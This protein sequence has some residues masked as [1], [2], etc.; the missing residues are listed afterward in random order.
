MTKYIVRF[1]MTASNARATGLK[2]CNSKKEFVRENAAKK[3]A[4]EMKASDYIVTLHSFT[5]GD[6]YVG[7]TEVSF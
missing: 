5:T 3:F 2:M 7:E 6:A 1:Q 4:A